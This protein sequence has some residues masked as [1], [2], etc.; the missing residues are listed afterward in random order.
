M[1]LVPGFSL[2]PSDLVRRGRPTPITAAEFEETQA[3]DPPLVE[4]LL[5]SLKGLDRG[6]PSSLNEGV[7]NVTAVVLASVFLVVTAD[8]ALQTYDHHFVDVERLVRVAVL[9]GVAWISYGWLEEARTSSR[10]LEEANYCYDHLAPRQRALSAY[11][12]GILT[13]PGAQTEDA[14]V[15]D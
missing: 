1:A 8:V 9:V 15:E 14:R 10:Y 6:A 12:A 3:Q 13:M 5:R 2:I 11:L 7:S 4:R